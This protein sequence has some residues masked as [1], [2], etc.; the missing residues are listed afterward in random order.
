M[1]LEEMKTMWTKMSAE[2][3]KQKKVTDSLIIKMTETNYRTKLGRI[4]A[5]EIAGAIICFAAMLFIFI[6][7]QQLH[8]GYLLACGICAIVILFLLCW[9]PLKAIWKIHS[10]S[11]ET[12][13]YKQVLLEYS[14]S[15]KRFVFVQKLSF[16]LS[17]VLLLVALPVMGML[18]AG[19][20]LF[21]ETN[22]WMFYAVAFPCF[23][24]FSKWVYKSYSN[25]VADAENILRGL[26]G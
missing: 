23:Y 4:L 25:M 17:A 21:K 8:P 1:E 22:F 18:I 9:L 10:I 7:I 20:D 11:I 15:K 6:N 24:P 12:K 19:K 16:Y 13:S 2:I 26:E 3:E 5:P 14:T